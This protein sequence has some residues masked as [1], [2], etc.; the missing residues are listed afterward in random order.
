M[1][2]GAGEAETRTLSRR[3]LP[4]VAV[5]RLAFSPDGKRLVAATDLGT[6]TAWDVALQAETFTLYGTYGPLA[7]APQGQRLVLARSDGSLVVA[8]PDTGERVCKVPAFKGK[9]SSV[10]FRGDGSLVAAVAGE[11]GLAVQVWKAGP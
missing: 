1:F 5:K 7:F 2:S 4:G 9:V 10:A 3:E 11:S 8:K 6:V